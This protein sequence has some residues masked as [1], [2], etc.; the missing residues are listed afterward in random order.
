MSKLQPGLGYT[1]TSDARGYS[2]SIDTPG[3]KRA[4]LEVYSNAIS[5]NQ[6]AVSVQPGSVNKVIP[7]INGN[8]LDAA[9]VPTLSVSNTG[10]VYLRATRASGSPFPATVDILF[11]TAV[12]ADTASIGYL[13]LASVTKTG[14]SLQISQLVRSSLV[15]ARVAT[16]PS[17]AYWYWFNV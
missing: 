13:A 11:G 10:Y 9:I 1:Y 12:P 4:P 17:G 16:S 8:D 6:P 15:T 3:R 2:L 7:K 5:E 14:N